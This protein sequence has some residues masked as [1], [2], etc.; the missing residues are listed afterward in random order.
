MIYETVIICAM[1]PEYSKWRKKSRRGYL[2]GIHRMDRM[3]AFRIN[4]NILS[5]VSCSSQL[6]RLFVMIWISGQAAWSLSSCATSPPQLLLPRV[7]S[8]ARSGCSVEGYHQTKRLV[9]LPNLNLPAIPRLV[10]AA[11]PSEESSC[12]RVPAVT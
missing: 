2:T 3:K 1:S 7:S 6:R 5:R 9:K 11:P 10:P 12:T 8:A 4:L